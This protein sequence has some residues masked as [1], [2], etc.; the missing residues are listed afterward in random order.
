[1]TIDFASTGARP[2]LLESVICLEGK[3]REFFPFGLHA[4]GCLVWAPG[5]LT[6]NPSPRDAGGVT[7]S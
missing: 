4:T 5:R 7:L 1:M 3:A 6:R 2:G